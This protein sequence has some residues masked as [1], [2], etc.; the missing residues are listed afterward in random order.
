MQGTTGRRKDQLVSLALHG[1][2]VLSVL[3]LA[4][5]GQVPVE[6]A[7]WVIRPAVYA[8]RWERRVE[9]RSGHW[10]RSLLAW[11]RAVKCY[12]VQSWQPVLLRGLLLW[13]LWTGW[14]VRAGVWVGNH[15][16]MHRGSSV[17]PR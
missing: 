2:V 3:G 17:T 10:R 5:L 9:R 7:G 15:A 4:L 12:L 14:G 13:W 8:E 11:S 16:Q 6:A 1:M